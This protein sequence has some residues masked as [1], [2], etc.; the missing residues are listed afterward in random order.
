MKFNLCAS[1]I[2]AAGLFV[3]N[4]KSRYYLCGVYAAP[5]PK[6]GVILSATDGGKLCL[7]HDKDGS[8]SRPA[9][10]D[11]DFAERRLK[12]NPR[13]G[14]KR[15]ALDQTGTEG[16]LPSSPAIIHERCDGSELGPSAGF[17]TVAEIDGSY[18]WEG[19]KRMFK[20][21]HL[22]APLS[23]TRCIIPSDFA[24]CSNAAKLLGASNGNL[25]LARDPKDPSGPFIARPW[26]I[27]SALF[28]VMPGLGHNDKH[29]PDFAWAAEALA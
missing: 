29:V 10:L 13:S 3:S 11:L 27:S 12:R 22:E 18:P 6:G 24:D 26:G 16:T 23:G 17:I 14:A 25:H 8:I 4:D 21:E 15:I 5:H 28:L 7:I 20:M 9:L 19:V 2:A 1:S